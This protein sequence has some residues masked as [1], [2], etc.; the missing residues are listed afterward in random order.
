[1]LAAAL[2][3]DVAD[4]DVY[5]RVMTRTLAE[6]LPRDMVTV[7]RERTWS[8]RLAGRPGTV[9]LVSIHTAT[10][11]LELSARQDR[12]PKASIAYR[13]GEMVVARR[14]VSVTEWVHLLAQELHARAEDSAAARAAL[15][16]L[17]GG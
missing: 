11:D 3:A 15:A 10:G 13:V 16:R 12:A 5:A 4:L 1:M 17:L 14:E 6:A 9:T 7:E 2:R 8:D